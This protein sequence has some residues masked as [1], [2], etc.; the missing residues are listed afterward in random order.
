MEIIKYRIIHH[1]NGMERWHYG[2]R[3]HGFRYQAA[4]DAVEDDR[5]RKRIRK[6]PKTLLYRTYFVKACNNG[7]NS[8]YIHTDFTYL[9]PVHGIGNELSHV[10]MHDQGLDEK[11]KMFRPI[12]TMQLMKLFILQ[13]FYLVHKT[14]ISS[15]RSHTRIELGMQLNVVWLFDY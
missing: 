14:K 10:K 15:S 8:L 5:R 13:I 12:S 6:H 9:A 2:F 1:C 3:Y 7:S 4:A 11:T